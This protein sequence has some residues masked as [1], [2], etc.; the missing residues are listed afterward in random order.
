MSYRRV[1]NLYS[2]SMGRIIEQLQSMFASNLLQLVQSAWLAVDMHGKDRAGPWRDRIFDL[3]WIQGIV[4]RLNVNKYGAYFI[5]KEG[6]GRGHERVR[7]GDDIP[8][9]AHPLERNLKCKCS[10]RKQR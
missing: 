8:R 4:F 10:I 6:V 9:D 3:F 2:E 1:A 7:S 5:P